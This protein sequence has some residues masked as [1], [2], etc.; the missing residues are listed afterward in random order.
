MAYLREYISQCQQ[1]VCTKAARYELR[2]AHNASCGFY[3]GPHARQALSRLQ[4]SEEATWAKA[5][6]AER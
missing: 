4:A 2:N 5:R 1:D 6:E 3:C